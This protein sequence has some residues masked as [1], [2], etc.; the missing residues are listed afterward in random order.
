MQYNATFLYMSDLA[1]HLQ[2]ETLVTPSSIE[3]V[4]L[5]IGAYQSQLEKFN[6]TI[7]PSTELFNI[8]IESRFVKTQTEINALTFSSQIARIAHAKLSM[9]IA[10]TESILAARFNLF[11][12]ECGARLQAYNP[13]VGCGPHAATLHF[14][15]GETPDD[16]MSMI[17]ENSFILVDAAP[18]WHGYASDLTRTYARSTTPQMR[19]IHQIVTIAQQIGL[20]AHVMGNTWQNMCARTLES[21]LVGLRATGIV[22]GP[23]EELNSSDVVKLFMPHGVGHP[24]GLDVHDHVPTRYNGN[25][26]YDYTLAPGHVNTVEPGIYFIPFLLDEH[27][28]GDTKWTRYVNWTRVDEFMHVGGVRIEDVVIIDLDGVQRIITR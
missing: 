4:N 25:G 15:T 28:R 16:G 23:W 6:V 12:T 3:L 21:L 26:T 20:D 13:I 14:P 2:N 27:R 1:V 18:E 5:N 17:P 9:D 7:K 22:Y 19:I 24:V 11:S 8:F 10:S